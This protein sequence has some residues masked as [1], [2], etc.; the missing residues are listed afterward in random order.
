MALKREKEMHGS[1]KSNINLFTNLRISHYRTQSWKKIFSNQKSIA[2]KLIY[3]ERIAI[4]T[5]TGW[6]IWTFSQQSIPA[7]YLSNLETKWK[8]FKADVEG[9]E[10][11]KIQWKQIDDWVKRSAQ[12]GI[13]KRET[14]SRKK[15]HAMSG[16]SF[17]FQMKH[18]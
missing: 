11:S 17:F 3:K 9:K 5:Y 7:A 16:F 18:K 4:P 10:H 2:Q 6:R 13:L 14:G 8:W 15:L 1:Y 12:K